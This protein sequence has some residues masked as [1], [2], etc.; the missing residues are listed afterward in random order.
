MEQPARIRPQRKKGMIMAASKYMDDTTPKKTKQETNLLIISEHF[1]CKFAQKHFL[2][3]TQALRQPI[4]VERFLVEERHA[5]LLII[6]SSLENT[7][8][9]KPERDSKA[10]NFRTH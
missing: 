1:R 4:R 9:P 5:K 6:K 8:S 2:V 3:V 7:N 10:L